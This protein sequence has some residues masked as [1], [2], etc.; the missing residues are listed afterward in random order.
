M[1]ALE[2]E[3]RS[4]ECFE[5]KAVIKSLCLGERHILRQEVG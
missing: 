5:R 4:V 3:D 2:P 1:I